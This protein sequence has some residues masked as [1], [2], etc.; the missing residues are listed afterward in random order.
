MGGGGFHTGR[1]ADV[2]KLVAEKAGWGRQV[3]PG[4]GLGL[5]FHYSHQGYFAEVAEVSVD[6]NKKLTIHKVWVAGDIGPIVNMSAAENQV[7]GSIID[8]FSTMLAQEITFEGGA[9]QQKNL[10]QYPLLRMPSAPEIE[11]HFLQSNNSPTG[12][13]E[14]ALPP[15][16]P[17]VAN[18]IFAAIGERVRT[19]PLSKA[20]YTA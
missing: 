15:L 20:G 7:Q 12:C 3:A 13:G 19:L 4:R 8:G 16:A 11:V 17:A 10:H 18:A 1:A 9:V 6:A 2:I 14:P 5:A